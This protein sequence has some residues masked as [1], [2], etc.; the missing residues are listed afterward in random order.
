MN[1]LDPMRE[2]IEALR[3]QTDAIKAHTKGLEALTASIKILEKLVAKE[4][5]KS[6]FERIFGRD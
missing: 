6:L 1:G 3:L 4:T 5:E 2:L